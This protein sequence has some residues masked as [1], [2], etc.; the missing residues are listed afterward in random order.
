MFCK[1]KTLTGGILFK[2]KSHLRYQVKVTILYDSFFMFDP[3][4]L[5]FVIISSVDF[6][7]EVATPNG[8]FL[9]TP[10]VVT[11]VYVQFALVI[12]VVSMQKFTA[13][14]WGARK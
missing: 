12:C 11:L 3:F 1:V 10:E 7:V 4:S 13:K 2:R 9:S 14:E 6:S 8:Q 5:G